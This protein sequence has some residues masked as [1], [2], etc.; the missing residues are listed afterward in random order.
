MFMIDGASELTRD[1]TVPK[2]V[3]C[4]INRFPY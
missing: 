2:I 4:F 3:Y 1:T